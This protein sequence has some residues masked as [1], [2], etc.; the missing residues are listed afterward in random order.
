MIRKAFYCIGI[1]FLAGVV[2][3]C[4]TITTLKVNKERQE[5]IV[6]KQKQLEQIERI[7][8]ILEEERDNAAKAVKDEQDTINNQK[9]FLLSIH[10]ELNRLRKEIKKSSHA[11]A[12][13]QKKNEDIVRKINELTAKIEALK[14]TGTKEFEAEKHKLEDELLILLEILEER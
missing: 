11:T 12:E 3:S 7:L 10:D 5:R 8:K 13:Q 14:Q 1:V 2:I 6:Q 4:S 9:R